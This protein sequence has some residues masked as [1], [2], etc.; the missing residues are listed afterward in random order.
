MSRVHD[1][2]RRAEQISG[3]APAASAAETAAADVPAAPVSTGAVVS[4]P[5]DVLIP[6][7]DISIDMLSR[8]RQVPFT[9]APDSHLIS[10]DN[11]QKSPAEEFRSLRTR[12]N[13]MQ[14]MQPLNT[15][16]VTSPSPAEGKSFAAVNLAIAEAQLDGNN[17]LLIDC[18]FR[19]PIV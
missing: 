10:F 15:V 18:D 19:R 1:A 2:L 4:A 14:S 7:A 13:H 12:L 11:P 5:T 6:P 16:V 3:Q 9:P 17:T 8:I